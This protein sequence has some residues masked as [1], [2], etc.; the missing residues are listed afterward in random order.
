MANENL[1]VICDPKAE[2]PKVRRAAAYVRVSSA[3]EKQLHSFSA[4]KEYWERF[5]AGDPMLRLV[6]VWADEGLSGHTMRNRKQFLALVQAA[7]QGEI[8]I[9]FTKAV[10]RFGRNLLDVLKTVR[11]LRDEYG[12]VC[13]FEEENLYSDEPMADT[14]LSMRAMVAEQELQDMSDNQKWSIRKRFRQGLPN[15]NGRFYGYTLAADQTGVKRI[16]PNPEEAEVVRLIFRLF[17]GGMGHEAIAKKLTEMGI[18]APKGGKRWGANT[19]AKMLKNEKYTSDA[20]FQKYKTDNFVKRENKGDDP[21]APLIY[22]ENDHEGIIDKATFTKAQAE[23]ARRVNHK[24]VGKMQSAREFSSLL[25]CAHCGGTL[26][27]KVYHYKGKG[28]YGFWACVKALKSGVSVCP[29]ARIKDAELEKAFVSA[30]NEFV[31]LESKEDAVTALS[32]QLEELNRRDG[33]LYNLLH[34]GYINKLSYITEHQ[35]LTEEIGKLDREIA[36]KSQDNIYKAYKKRLA[37][38]D[39]QAV[40]RF[41]KKAVI[42]KTVAAFHFKNGVVIERKFSNGPS[43]NHV[44]WKKEKKES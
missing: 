32:E 38:Y 11:E 41:L 14:I 44:G 5:I 30:F 36:A 19:I 42:G 13:Y 7:K 12:V 28:L 6:G 27:H 4:Q 3:S 20:V 35:R 8:N 25:F 21:A 15:N 26:N 18:V 2:K 40:T 23:T 9:I 37:E 17:L 10:S 43:G 39:P 22:I 24:L 29:G 1:R 33:E 34:G 16:T 31:G